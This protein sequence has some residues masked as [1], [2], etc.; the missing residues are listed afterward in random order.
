MTQQDLACW[1]LAGTC[2]CQPAQS[3]TQWLE[4]PTS[5]FGATADLKVMSLPS[6]AASD[7]AG[8]H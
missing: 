8:L 7:H 5:Y 4:D 1:A 2:I 3:L 6:V